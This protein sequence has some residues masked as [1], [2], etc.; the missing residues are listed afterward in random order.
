MTSN[1]NS[2]AMRC[3]LRRV[4][5]CVLGGASL[6]TAAG[7]S[8]FDAGMRSGAQDSHP[9]VNVQDINPEAASTSIRLSQDVVHAPHYMLSTANPLAT[10]AGVDVLA[11]GGSAADAAIASQMVLNLVEPQSSGIGG[12]AF[13]V[14]YDA[15]SQ[16]VHAYDGR[17]T[18]PAAA[19]SDQFMA[20]GK[21]IPFWEA[22][23]S[24]RS[25]GAPGLLGVLALMHEQDGRLSWARLFA[26]A[27]A[28]A[29]E[30]F[31]VSPR[32]HALL[33]NNNGLREQQAAA[34]YFYDANGEPW[35]VG[36][37]LVNKA[38]AQVFREVAAHGANAFYEGKLAQ[39]IVAA[40]AGHAIPGD[41]SLQDLSRYRALERAPLCAPYKI[42]TLCG[43]PPPSS[44]PLTVMQI[45]NILSHTDIAALPPNSLEAVHYFAEA[46]KLAYADRDVYVA[47][48]AFINVP[49]KAMLDPEYLALRASL[50]QPDRTIGRAPPGDPA[51]MLAIRGKD[52]SLQQPSTTH[53]SAVD[54]QGNV[55]SMT[56][57]IES[58]FGSKIFVR[59]FLLNNQLTDFSLSDVD[60]Q[61]K[62][63]ANRLEPLKR[64]RSSM[65]P[66]LVLKDGK[67]IMAIGSPGGSAIINYVAKTLLG[68]LDWGL[69]IQQA[70]ALPNRG[71]RNSFTELEKGTSLHGLAGGLRAM[72]HEVREIDFPSGL[73]GIVV[74]PEGLEGGSDPRREGVSAGG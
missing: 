55:V 28:L 44:G 13:I 1:R 62:P 39:D 36:H 8:A 51:G 3:V 9:P 42:Y 5:A 35:P 27:I 11:E 67:P 41:L 17:E 6:L 25:V 2:Y 71:S 50:I 46:G 66:M 63:V 22:V 10:K 29:E 45:L 53:I 58:A 21:A 57:S 20:D 48:P 47:D 43:M 65:A 37:I 59:G 60:A 54:A 74:T 61:D 56:S 49:V 69:N 16:S 30:G 64:P 31:P 40:V 72:G 12:G 68:V 14:S 4:A 73:Q 18:A 7:V 38:L 33:E 24:G 15:A 23:N 52:T 70:I 19:R 32:L 26:P 34:A